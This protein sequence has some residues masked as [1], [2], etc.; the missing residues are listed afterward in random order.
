MRPLAPFRLI[1]LAF[2][3]LLSGPSMARAADAVEGDRLG[4]D[5]VPTRQAVRLV[6]DADKPDYTGTVSVALQV[7]RST[8]AIR[9]HARALTVDAVTL[10]GPQGAVVVKGIDKP[11]PDQARVTLAKPLVPGAYMATISFHNNYNTRAVALYKVETGGHSYLFTQFEATEARE[12]F[13]CWDE[14]E[15]KIPWQLRLAV[16]STHMAVSNTPIVSET[17]GADGM[18]VVTFLETKP[19][20]SYL[21][22]IATGPLES[23]EIPG[24]SVPGRVITVKGQTTLAAE[25]VKVT[26]PILKALEDYFG[27]PY[28]YEKLDLI[29]APEFL[30]GA[31]ENAGAVVF[32]DRRLLVVPGGASAE[33]QR[34]LTGVIA[35]EL[36]HMW[37]G[38][39]V[40]MKWWDDLWLNESFATWMATHVMDRVFP[41]VHSGLL[42]LIGYQRAFATDSRP[43]TNAMRQKV[44]SADNL[45]QMANDLAY[46]KGEAVLTMFEG[47]L[48]V[49]TFRTGVIAYLKAHEWSNAEGQDLWN[50]LSEASGQDIGAAMSTFL[51]QPGVPLVRVEPRADGSVRLTQRR[52]LTSGAIAPTS[53][54]WRI[55]VILRFAHGG[56]IETKRVWLTDSVET[57]SLGIGHAPE[58]IYPS[59]G[60]SGYYRWSVPDPM[61][62]KLATSA[63]PSL[64]PAERMGYILNLTAL[65][66]AG[67]VRGDD[68]LKRVGRFADDSAPEVISV[69]IDML[70][71]SRVSLISKD[72][73]ES[74]AG[75]LRVTLD[76]A[77]DRIGL[78]K[79]T[80][81]PLGYSYTRPLL[82]RFLGDA[83]RDR[84]VVA[85]AESLGRAYLQDPRAIDPSL[86][87][88]S[89]TLPAL[90][91]GRALFEEYRK[92]FEN[93]KVPIERTLYLAGL[94][95]FRD[96]QLRAAALDY[97]LKGPL[98]PQEV[99]Q[100]PQAMAVNAM[101]AEWRGASVYPD[102][103]FDWTL[104]RHAEIATRL[105]PNFLVRVMSLSQGC[106]DD[107]LAA[108]RA[109]Y[110]E[111][112]HHILGGERAMERMTDAT[113]DCI[114]LRDREARRVAEYLR[115][116]TARP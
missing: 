68:Y 77:M 66:R 89:I 33:Q 63:R 94:G 54:L 82:M 113:K 107:R 90:R 14:P 4:R 57:V 3:L 80:G 13:P 115:S 28:P 95:S 35:H 30:Y 97:A 102:A 47:W 62:E 48:S 15:F 49:P 106:G 93:T 60:A 37:F 51:E 75:W 78:G 7:R 1:S 79:T 5:V 91:G 44:E 9:F 34:Q 25:A 72:Q 96:P 65:L 104:K 114:S 27:R 85:Y 59:A 116:V 31:M 17:P 46:Q 70:N 61:L 38:D 52:F 56:K 81:E 24:M 19:L 101:G 11:R 105:P 73:E 36:A 55:P 8:D 71:E 29:A 26:P 10:T 64:D 86:A 50:A 74:F 108:A 109:F 21:I 53:Q 111:P 103:V 18:K 39:L 67:E 45:N 23:V 88:V 12:A 83:G 2:V 41:D 69:L 22:A 76:P 16:P 32:A 84:R 6:L 58:W 42:S 110:S 20:P 99:L 100:V 112:T 92:R 87:E 43:S 40:T 98:R